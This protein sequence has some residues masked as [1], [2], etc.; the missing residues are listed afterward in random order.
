M[1][2]NTHARGKHEHFQLARGKLRRW[3]VYTQYHTLCARFSV[4]K[5]GWTLVLRHGHLPLHR[6]NTAA[7]D[8]RGHWAHPDVAQGGL[9]DAESRVACNADHAC[10]FL[11]TPILCCQSI[12]TYLIKVMYQIKSRN[13]WKSKAYTAADCFHNLQATAITLN[14]LK[15][16]V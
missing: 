3:V 8:S 16:S 2:D 11:D 10:K 13:L 12:C 6:I 1:N 14:L 15:F 9:E 5:P 4:T 7:K